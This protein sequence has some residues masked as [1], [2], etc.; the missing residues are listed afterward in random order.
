M[1]ERKVYR[2]R[3]DPTAKQEAA[4]ARYAGARRFIFNWA[5]QRRKETYAQ[6]G[7][8]ISWS[9][10]SVELTGLKN[11]PGFDWLKEIDSVV[12]ASHSRLQEGV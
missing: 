6:T 9:E 10:L 8:S 4:L 3:I 12:A 2:F 5:L 7:K 11:K 1:P